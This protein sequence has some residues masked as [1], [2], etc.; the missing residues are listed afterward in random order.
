MEIKRRAF[1]K[2]IGLTGIPS[3]EKPDMSSRYNPPHN[4][5]QTARLNRMPERVYAEEWKKYNKRHPAINCG[6]TS[7]E[8]ILAP[9]GYIRKVQPVSD[10][11]AE[12]AA[13]VI[14]WLGT[15][16]GFHFTLECEAKIKALK[17]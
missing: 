13:S 17:S 7:L 8:L 15:N 10:R 12:V 6:F 11:D 4:S 16:C 1:L 9:E 5:L 14:Q 3:D 2:L